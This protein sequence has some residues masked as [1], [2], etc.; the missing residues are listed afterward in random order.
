MPKQEDETYRGDDRVRPLSTQG[1]RP[2]QGQGIGAAPGRVSSPEDPVQPVRRCCE[3][4]QPLA[5]S[6]GLGVESVDEL[7]EG[8]GSDAVQL[9]TKMAGES[10]VVCTHGDV[11]AELL[12]VLKPRADDEI[13][14]AM[15]LQKGEVWVV[16]STRVP[17]WTIVEHI[18]QRPAHL[19]EVRIG[20]L[21]ATLHAQ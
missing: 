10:A 19:D 8:H 3:T 16:R 21:T 5:E 13:R 20:Q 7:G 15:R 12:E 14:A 17:R 9:M 18:S 11:A 2:A 1:K 4:V 6:L